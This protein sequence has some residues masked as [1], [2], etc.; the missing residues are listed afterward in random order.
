VNQKGPAA[1]SSTKSRTPKELPCSLGPR[2]RIR[3]EP[4]LIA[5]PTCDRIE[6]DLFKLVTQVRQK[7]AAESTRP[8]ARVAR[9]GSQARADAAARRAGSG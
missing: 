8:R 9:T 3:T 1:I 4:K 7:L 6:V 5:C 2:V